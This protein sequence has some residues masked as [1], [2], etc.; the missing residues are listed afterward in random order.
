MQPQPPVIHHQTLRLQIWWVTAVLISINVGLYLWQ[1]FTGVDSATPSLKDAIVWGADYAPLTLLYEPERLLTSMFF[2][3]G[4]IHL[5]MNMWAL[6]LF[7]QIAEQIYGKFYFIG[8]Y[9]IAGLGGSLLSSW[10]NI[11]DSQVFL[12]DLQNTAL[13]PHVSAGASGAVMG[14]GGALTFLSLLPP[15]NNQPLILN[16]KSLIL[17][18][19]INLMIGIFTPNI[20]NWAHLGGV[21]LGIVLSAIYY[22]FDQKDRPLY[23]SIIGLITG[24]LL[25]LSLYLYCQT[26]LSSITPLWMTLLQKLSLTD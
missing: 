20:N 17:I 11:Y 23:G 13:L 6:Y 9:L 22:I 26:Q 10:F 25:C 16:A 19:L 2:H 5:A 1:I 3:F 12:K 21:L 24:C 14:L 8:L 15:T 18:M 7:G 4:F